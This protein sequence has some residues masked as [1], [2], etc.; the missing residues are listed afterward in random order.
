MNAYLAQDIAPLVGF[1]TAMVAVLSIP[2]RPGG[3]FNRAAKG[4]FAAS[5]LCYLISTLASVLARLGLF[6]EYLDPAIVS[7]ELL[8][9][10]FILFGVYSLHSNQQLNDA[11][12]A[13]R[14]VKK[15]GEM[16]ESVM[17]TVPSGIMVLSDAGGI[18]FANAEARRLLDLLDDTAEALS[19]PEWTVQYAIAEGSPPARRDFRQLVTRTALRNAQVTVAWPSGWHRHLTVNTAPFDNAAGD[20]GGAVAAFLERSPSPG[21]VDA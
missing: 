12:S 2:V 17:E 13:R 4:F 18:T 16:L 14:A 6:P 15:A 11:V 7:V 3:A 19:C 9:V 10:P 8:W 1:A 5:I 20:L 21:P